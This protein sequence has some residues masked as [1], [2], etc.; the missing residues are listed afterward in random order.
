M[1]WTIDQISYQRGRLAISSNFPQS[2]NLIAKAQTA[3]HCVAPDY[4]NRPIQDLA[5]AVG[6]DDRLS[7]PMSSR[8]LL[9]TLMTYYSNAL[10][11]PMVG[12]NTTCIILSSNIL[13][14]GPR[15]L[16]ANKGQDQLGVFS[17]QTTNPVCALPND[18]CQ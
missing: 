9:S 13:G 16:G 8:T 4:L 5:V 2:A 14:L 3:D 15:L 18:Y 1:T 7:K 17:A 12:E 6:L 10:N 11:I